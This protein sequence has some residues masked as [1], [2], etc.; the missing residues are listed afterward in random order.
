MKY[1][2]KLYL[3]YSSW[4][5]LAFQY[6]NISTKIFQICNRYAVLQAIS[7]KK[8]FKFHW[9][10]LILKFSECISTDLLC[11][12]CAGLINYKPLLSSLECKLFIAPILYSLF[13]DA[14]IKYM[15][16]IIAHIKL[17]LV[18]STLRQYY[19]M[20]FKVTIWSE[21]NIFSVY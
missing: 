5:Q 20:S 16:T 4:K 3:K 17:F 1:I 2:L 12:S 9:K 6:M 11:F 18:N 13:H 15:C 14:F 10:K 19:N 8:S 7:Y 21:V